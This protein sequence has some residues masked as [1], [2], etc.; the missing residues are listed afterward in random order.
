MSKV[1]EIIWPNCGKAATLDVAGYTDI[2]KQVRGTG[3]EKR[4]HERLELVD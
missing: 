3:F 4:L 1:R 2:L